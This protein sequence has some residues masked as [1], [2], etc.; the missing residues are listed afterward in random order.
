ME[1]SFK[2]LKVLFPN[3][4]YS[5]TLNISS[6]ITRFYC[7]KLR[8][9]GICANTCL[10]ACKPHLAAMLLDLDKGNSPGA[11]LTWRAKNEAAK[12]LEQHR[13]EER[14]EPD[15]YRPVIFDQPPAPENPFLGYLEKLS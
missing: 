12:M 3:T 15:H 9:N 14:H 11:L 1:L 10:T 5:H 8:V 13:E 4:T 7:G 2:I 6:I